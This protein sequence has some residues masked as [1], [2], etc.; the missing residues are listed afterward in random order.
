MAI[1]VGLVNVDLNANDEYYSSIDDV[2]LGFVEASCEILA[3]EY[4]EKNW[5]PNDIENLCD[6][7]RP[8]Y[9]IRVEELNVNPK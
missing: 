2:Y 3:L 5:T 1:F 4:F 9:E 6:W 7:V 8:N